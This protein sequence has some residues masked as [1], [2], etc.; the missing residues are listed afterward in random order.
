MIA[1]RRMHSGEEG[2]N[3]AM[4]DGSDEINVFEQHAAACG[5]QAE[6]V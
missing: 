5:E 3:V 4:L 6:D 2:T 1:D